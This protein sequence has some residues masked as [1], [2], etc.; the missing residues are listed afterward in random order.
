MAYTEEQ[1]KEWGYNHDWTL[2]QGI[3]LLKNPKKI[4]YLGYWKSDESWPEK[5]DLVSFL[6]P[7]NLDSELSVRNYHAML[8]FLKSERMPDN[9]IDFRVRFRNLGTSGLRWDKIGGNVP[10]LTLN[11]KTPHNRET[12]NFVIHDGG[13]SACWSSPESNL[14]RYERKMQ[15]YKGPNIGFQVR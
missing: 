12:L 2:N 11:T 4:P 13:Y 5:I 8:E 6:R 14:M 3:N 9:S 1:L 10:F 15:E 7:D